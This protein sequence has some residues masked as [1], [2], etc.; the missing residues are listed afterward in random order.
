M[1]VV[2]FLFD[3]IKRSFSLWPK[4]SLCLTYSQSCVNNLENIIL[5]N[6]ILQNI[7][8]I[9]IRIVHKK[10]KLSLFKW[11]FWKREEQTKFIYLKEKGKIIACR[12]NHLKLKFWMRVFFFRLIKCSNIIKIRITSAIRLQWFCLS[13]IN[14]MYNLMIFIQRENWK[15]VLYAKLGTSPHLSRKSHLWTKT[16]VSNSTT[17]CQLKWEAKMTLNKYDTGGTFF[18]SF[19]HSF[20]LIFVCWSL[21]SPYF[22]GLSKPN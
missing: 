8:F 6:R 4:A 5:Q 15:I 1:C 10:L 7:L 20:A 12:E 18:L 19:I 22:S 11:M 21:S 14:V 9:T 13:I 16:N 2:W 17:K 3:F